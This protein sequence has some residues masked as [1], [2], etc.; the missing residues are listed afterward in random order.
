MNGCTAGGVAAAQL[1][2]AAQ[3]L[4]LAPAPSDQE[5]QRAHAQGSCG[6]MGPGTGLSGNKGWVVSMMPG[7][8]Q[9]RVRGGAGQ[10][11]VTAARQSVVD[12]DVGRPY[13]LVVEGAGPAPVLEWK[14]P[15]S[16]WGVVS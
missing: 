13:Y 11:Y 5:A 8:H 12:F 3:S 10:V 4:A 7:K 15:G 2:V 1:L 16:A 14:I 6:K 9:F